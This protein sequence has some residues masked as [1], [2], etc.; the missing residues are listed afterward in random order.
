MS[1]AAEPGMGAFGILP[2]GDHKGNM[3]VVAQP[4][5]A[6]RPFGVRFAE[7]PRPMQ[8]CPTVD[9]STWHY[10]AVRQIAMIYDGDQVIEA[11]KHSTG[12]TQTPTNS[13][14]GTRYE[15]D[16]DVTED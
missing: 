16:D 8:S 15:R 3:P 5:S 7:P 14:D 9:F 1:V 13:S 11:G 2:Y 6:V 12:P 10:D 4:S